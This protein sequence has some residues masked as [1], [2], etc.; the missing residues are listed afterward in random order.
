MDDINLIFIAQTEKELAAKVQEGSNLWETCLRPTGG[1]A[2]TM[3]TF[4]YKMNF[5]WDNKYEDI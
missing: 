2:H 4:C 3:K 1:A 5:S